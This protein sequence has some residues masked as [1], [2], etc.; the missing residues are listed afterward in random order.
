MKEIEKRIL[1]DGIIIDNDIIRVDSFL[2]HQVDPAFLHDFARGVVS[3]FAGQKIDKVLTCETS[4]IAAAHAVAVELGNVP[5][6]FAKKT[7][8][9]TTVGQFYHAKVKSFTRN[10][11]SDIAVAC[12]Y[13]LEGENVLIVD[14]FLA[15]GNAASGLLEI[16]RQAKTNV[17]GVAVVI[18]KAFQKGHSLLLEQG[19]DL[20][21]GAS[22]KA[23]V[24]NKPVF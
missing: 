14:E 15:D 2:N 24:D 8:S 11:E 9:K 5:Y 22:I 18:E 3:H 6:V 10:S 13:L 1:D 21:A 23:F 20:Y 16:C 19:I 4:G 7:Q 12:R 17:I